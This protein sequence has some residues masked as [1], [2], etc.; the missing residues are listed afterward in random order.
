MAFFFGSWKSL[1]FINYPDSGKL[2]KA[3]FR[4]SKL[5]KNTHSAWHNSWILDIT[6]NAWKIVFP[7]LENP[8]KVLDFFPQIAVWTLFYNVC[9]I[10]W[11]NNQIQYHA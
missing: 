10:I 1:L 7:L 3:D 9:I 8:G 11:K 4:F 2:A 6:E 5:E